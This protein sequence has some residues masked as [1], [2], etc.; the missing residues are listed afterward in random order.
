MGNFSSIIQPNK[1]YGK[2]QKGFDIL[3]TILRLVGS[4]NLRFDDI[5]IFEYIRILEYIHEYFLQIIFLFRFVI[6]DVKNNINTCICKICLLQ[7]I[8]IFVFIRQKNYLLHSDM[9]Q[10]SG[11]AWE[12]GNS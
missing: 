9:H 3:S 12:H 4:S 1:Q 8:F 7:I 10:H 5:Q 6:Q 11:N 2:L